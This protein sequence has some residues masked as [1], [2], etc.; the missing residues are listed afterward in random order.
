M[1]KTLRRFPHAAVVLELHLQRDPP[2][3]VGLLHQVE[4]AGFPLRSI[5]YDGE[6]VLTDADTIL[7]QPHEHWTLWLQK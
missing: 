3:T 7:A 5:H 2:Q 4:R 6:V 1:Q